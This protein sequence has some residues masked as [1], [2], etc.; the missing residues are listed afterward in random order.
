[1][2]NG[3]K[4]TFSGEREHNPEAIREEGDK[5]RERLRL[6][7]NLEQRS[8][9]SPESIEDARREVERAKFE[10]EPVKVERQPSPAELR[11]ER[12][13]ISKK[14]RDES[15]KATMHEVHS[16]MSAPSRVFSKVI[17]N[18]AVEKVSEVAGSTVARPN[19]MLSGA[20]FAFILTLAVYLVAKNLGYPLS[21]FETIAAFAIGWALGVVYDFLKIMVTGRK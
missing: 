8:K 3:E 12:G 19:A 2:T 18:K 14:K 6:Q 16:Q 1:M 13:P 10:Q 4:I 15:F 11:R 7:E 5:Q 20:I 17:H 9:K 21:G